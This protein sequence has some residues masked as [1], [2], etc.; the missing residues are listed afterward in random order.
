MHASSNN[1]SM[2]LTR[3]LSAVTV[4]VQTTPSLSALIKISSCQMYHS[5][6]IDFYQ[7]YRFYK[8]IRGMLQKSNFVR[9]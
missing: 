6:D 9:H 5:F 3:C 2:L 1:C 4:D 8:H 7:K